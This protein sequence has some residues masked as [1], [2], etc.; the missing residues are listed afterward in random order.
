MSR[1]LSLFLFLFF[2]SFF[3]F[4]FPVN[5]LEPIIIT[6]PI[7]H[8][9]P[10]AD[11][12][13]PKDINFYSNDADARNTVTCSAPVTICQTFEP[14]CGEKDSNGKCLSYTP[15]EVTRISGQVSFGVSD[16]QNEWYRR[17]FYHF[18]SRSKSLDD[19]GYPLSMTT[20][21]P[22]APSGSSNAVN[23]LYSEPVLSC[24]KGQRLYQSVLSLSNKDTDGYQVAAN[25]AVAWTDGTSVTEKATRPGLTPVRLADIAVAMSKALLDYRQDCLP[26]SVGESKFTPFYSPDKSCFGSTMPV[27]GSIPAN[28]YQPVL[29]D[30]YTA[31]RLFQRAVEVTDIGS[32]ARIIEIK[33]DESLKKGYSSIPIGNLSTNEEITK[34]VRPAQSLAPSIDVCRIAPSVQTN[35]KANSVTFTLVGIEKPFGTVDGEPQTFC[36]TFTRSYK[37]D[38]RIPSTYSNYNQSLIQFMPKDYILK[39]GLLDVPMGSEDGLGTYDPGNG[40]VQKFFYDLLRPVG[41][42]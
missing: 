35:D 8:N 17:T 5:A 39:N 26:Y 13:P 1:N 30:P 16:Y 31:C 22:Y 27:P 34:V 19:T 12:Q 33:D 29:K 23:R 7:N 14:K 3:I 42:Q 36:K 32:N 24:L 40:R 18:A 38:G 6:N 20:Y 21:D 4:H 15:Y 9:P 41:M 11:Q 28:N 2:S 25:E 10:V 37:I